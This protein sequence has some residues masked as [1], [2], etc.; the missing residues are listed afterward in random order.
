[1]GALLKLTGLETFMFFNFSRTSSGFSAFRSWKSTTASGFTEHR[2]AAFLTCSKLMSRFLDFACRRLGFRGA[3]GSGVFGVVS[4]G[5]NSGEENEE[6][7]SE[8]RY[9]VRARLVDCIRSQDCDIGRGI[10]FGR[11]CWGKSSWRKVCCG[12]SG[13]CWEEW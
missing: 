4:A 7:L 11:G 8:G 6:G 1:M 2:V 5:N 9:E 10:W 3:G 12:G 13:F